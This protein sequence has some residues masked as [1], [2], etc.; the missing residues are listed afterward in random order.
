MQTILPCWW[1]HLPCSYCLMHQAFSDT[2]QDL[3]HHRLAR[4]PLVPWLML[5]SFLGIL[6]WCTISISLS[7]WRWVMWL[8]DVSSWMG[9]NSSILGCDMMLFDELINTFRNTSEKP[10]AITGKSLFYYL[11]DHIHIFFSLWI[12]VILS[13]R[14]F[15][16]ENLFFVIFC[17]RKEHILFGL[18]A[19]FLA[20]FITLHE[21]VEMSWTRNQNCRPSNPQN[22]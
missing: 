2:Q 6:S 7:W 13:S 15:D 21:F 8:G 14:N 16:Y 4:F 9:T 5:Q 12:I 18:C 17:W 19:D 22:Q 11:H 10:P 20:W 3:W 1:C